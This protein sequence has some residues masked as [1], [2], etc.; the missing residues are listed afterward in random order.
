MCDGRD[1]GQEYPREGLLKVKH[2]DEIK[3]PKKWEIILVLL[4]LSVGVFIRAF[5]F[6]ISPV[7]VHQDEAM[8]AV[9]AKALADYGTD[10]FGM[11]WPVH[12]T[13]WIGGQMSVLLS[14]CMIPFIKLLGFS[15]FS[16]RLPMLVVS[17]IGLFAL[18]MLGR[19]IY[20]P[21]LG[22]ILLL[23]GVICPWHYMQ[24]RWSFDCNM[25]PHVFLFGVVFLLKG[26]EKK[27]S[28]YVAM[29]FFGLCCYCYGVADYSVPLFLLA[30]AVLLWKKEYVRVKEL[31]L[32]V[33]IYVIIVL[34][35]FLSMFLTVSGM[36][37]I[38]TPL[39]TIPSF[40]QSFRSRDILFTNFSWTQLWKNTI[41]TIVVVWG[42][43]DKSITN[44]I[45][46]FGPIYY[47]TTIFFLIGLAVILVRLIKKEAGTAAVPYLILLFWLA[48]GF[49]VGIITKEVTI[50]RINII[51]YPTLATAAVGML[52]CVE[53][54]RLLALPFLVGYG[55]AALLFASNYF[56]EWTEI[57][58]TYYYDP[59]ISALEYARTLECDR[60]YITPDPQGYGVNVGEILTLYCHEIDALYYQ[61]VSNMQDERERLPY[62]ERYHYENVTEEILAENTGQS[63]VY[64]V[65]AEDVPLFSQE[66][67]QFVSFYDGYYVISA[68]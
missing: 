2:L 49:W 54:C 31:I 18:Y 48:M 27:W 32:C 65:R 21:W 40:L 13:A 56:G 39:F 17:S 57:S 41:T 4:I 1:K 58:R 16:I 42:N 50:N 25:F 43:G 67:Y 37:S 29:V 47:P 35:E 15:T 24:S 30:A 38:E 10:R 53:K 12:F 26:L 34:P 46:K 28:L 14:Y 55:A 11:R 19:R 66:D 36:D 68:K 8:A 22:L 64:L 9:D 60:Y 61:G 59:Y 20:G 5:H 63:V 3:L 44:T 23:L 62:L 52:W 45:V 33:L 6:G 7:G 51:F